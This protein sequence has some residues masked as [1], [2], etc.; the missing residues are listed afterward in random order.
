M[1]HWWSRCIQ[2]GFHIK[3]AQEAIQF[4]TILG[5]VAA[6]T[7]IAIVPESLRALQIPGVAYL[8]LNDPAAHSQVSLICADTRRD[9]ALVKRF[10]DTADF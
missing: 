6:R 1:R 7:G 10:M 3:V 9:S 8:D 2:A 4:P 5:L